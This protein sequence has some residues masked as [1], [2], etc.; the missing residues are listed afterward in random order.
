MFTSNTFK[1]ECWPIGV[2]CAWHLYI[3]LQN[4]LGRFSAPTHLMLWV[5]FSCCKTLY[6]GCSWSNVQWGCFVCPS[7]SQKREKTAF[8]VVLLS[9][10]DLWVPVKMLQEVCRTPCQKRSHVWGTES[11]W[12]PRYLQQSRQCWKLEEFWKTSSVL[13]ELFHNHNNCNN[14]IWTTYKRNTIFTVWLSLLVK[15]NP[16]QKQR[17]NYEVAMQSVQVHCVSGERGAADL[18]GC[19]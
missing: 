3:C 7:C 4:W 2:W 13:Y 19:R 15:Q 9:T 11:D 10:G 18:C 17:Q 12:W 8:E 5:A 1:G 14:I 16:N 6:N